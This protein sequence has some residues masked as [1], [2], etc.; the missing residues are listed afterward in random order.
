M[1][2]QVTKYPWAQDENEESEH[3]SKPLGFQSL[4]G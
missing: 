1:H 3:T 4:S 2:L